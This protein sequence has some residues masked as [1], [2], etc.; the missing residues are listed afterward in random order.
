MINYDDKHK[1]KEFFPIRVLRWIGTHELTVLLAFALIISGMWLAAELAD[2]VLDGRTQQVDESILMALREGNDANNPLGPAWLEEM[3]RDFT[4][5][6]GTGILTLIVIV[7]TFYYLIQGRYK[8][9]LVLVTAVVGA[10]LLSYFFKG[11]FDRPRPEFVPIGDYAY[12]ASFPSGHALLSAATYLTMGTI[13]AQIMPR[14]RLKAFVLLIAFFV[15]TIVG[16]SRMYLG[17]HYPTDVLAGWAIGTVWA[18][19][20]WLVVR[21]LRRKQKTPSII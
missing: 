8:E 7:V 19:I 14:N 6:G 13:I 2:G 18:M 5:L 10:Y 4:A 15:M 21:F 11:L 12:T 9:A 17:V 3:M 20:C 16:F 1:T